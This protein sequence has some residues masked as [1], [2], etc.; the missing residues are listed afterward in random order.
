VPPSATTGHAPSSSSSSSSTTQ[1]RRGTDFTQ[2]SRAGES[3]ALLHTVLRQQLCASKCG[4]VGAGHTA[5]PWQ[6]PCRPLTGVLHWWVLGSRTAACGACRATSTPLFVCACCCHAG[7]IVEA[8]SK[9]VK[10]LNRHVFQGP[11]PADQQQQRLFKSACLT[12]W[13]ITV[14]LDSLWR[15]TNPVSSAERH[16]PLD[17]DLSQGV[18][19]RVACLQQTRS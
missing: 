12:C 16:R 5:Q 9:A 15:D 13:R 2:L 17:T 7:N 1:R 19:A 14:L 18:A 8:L 10:E 6:H 3:K 11:A 4:G